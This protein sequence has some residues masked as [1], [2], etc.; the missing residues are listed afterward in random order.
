M[1]RTHIYI[2][3]LKEIKDMPTQYVGKT[4]DG[5]DFYMGFRYGRMSIVVDGEYMG[6]GHLDD[7]IEGRCTLEDFM[8][9][10][11]ENG[12]ELHLIDYSHRFVVIKTD[13]VTP[14]VRKH[15]D[16]ALWLIAQKRDLEGKSNGHRYFVVNTDEP[17]ADEIRQIIK[18]EHGECEV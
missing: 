6:G 10:A 7:G 18:R 9:V 15:L 8:N 3:E 13:D 4:M 11:E 2:S 12:I 5:K 1:D 17:Y 14:E 16:T